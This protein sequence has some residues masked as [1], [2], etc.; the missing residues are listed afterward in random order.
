MRSP[1]TP[2]SRPVRSAGWPDAYAADT[3]ILDLATATD[4][5]ACAL[6]SHLVLFAGPAE[7]ARAPS[8]GCLR[9]T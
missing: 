5:L 1:P 4:V 2:S 6:S 7:L 8:Q 3:V 9:H